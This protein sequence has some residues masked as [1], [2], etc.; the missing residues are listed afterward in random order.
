MTSSY[1][2]QDQGDAAAA[3]AA[4]GVL[5]SSRP[6]RGAAGLR[7]RAVTAAAAAAAAAAAEAGGRGPGNGSWAASSRQLPAGFT[8]LQ[9]LGV[10]SWGT[11]GPATQLT[12]VQQH[13]ALVNV[14]GHGSSSSSGVA[15]DTQDPVLAAAAARAALSRSYQMPPRSFKSFTA[16]PFAA[17]AGTV[18]AAE[19]RSLRQ[20]YESFPVAAVTTQQA[21]QGENGTGPAGAWPLAGNGV[22]GVAAGHLGAGW[23]QQLRQ[24]GSV[25]GCG[26]AALVTEAAGLLMLPQMSPQ[27]QQRGTAAV[28]PSM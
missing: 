8:S 7:Q 4:A 23:Q 1:H 22:G 25:G 24:A 5:T 18:T 10:D 9:Q 28:L 14:P 12:T 6:F 19:M 26:G 2:W 17:A 15:S 20:S 11:V 21:L 16:G 27:Q 3:A 13:D